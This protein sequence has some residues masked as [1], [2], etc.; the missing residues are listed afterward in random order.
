[1]VGRTKETG[2]LIG[3]GLLLI[4]VNPASAIRLDFTMQM[5]VE[6]SSTRDPG[7]VPLQGCV[8]LWHCPWHDQDL[9]C[10]TAGSLGKRH[11]PRQDGY[12]PSLH[13]PSQGSCAS[14]HL[15]LHGLWSRS[16]LQ[17]E[18]GHWVGSQYP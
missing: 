14:M 18:V 6:Q 2:R 8:M 16:S 15:P 9:V 4:V 1:M 17:P 13:W 5:P 11:A 7:H 10:S 12:M 3:L